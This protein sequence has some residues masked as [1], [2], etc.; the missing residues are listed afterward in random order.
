MRR[1][2]DAFAQYLVRESPR[3]RAA[4][5]AVLGA[6]RLGAGEKPLRQKN[7]QKPSEKH[8]PLRQK[9]R[10]TFLLDTFSA[11]FR[12]HTRSV[13]NYPML[14]YPLRLLCQGVKRGPASCMTL[15][16]TRSPTPQANTEGFRSR[17]LRARRCRAD[18][19][20]VVPRG[21]MP[22]AER[23]FSAASHLHGKLVRLLVVRI[24]FL[25]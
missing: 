9:N 21:K 24:S 18:R 7:R 25:V 5:G 11:L 2:C 1:D 3:C 22:C 14:A 4:R 10:Q 17:F 6:S 13:L 15:C 20:S 8:L 23:I 16:V 19:I 12:W